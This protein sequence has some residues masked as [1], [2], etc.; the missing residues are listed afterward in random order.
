MEE[1]KILLSIGNN[2]EW[3]GKW[4]TVKKQRMKSW[5][6]AAKDCGELQT[7]REAEGKRRKSEYQFSEKKGWVRS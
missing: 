7:T 2:S 3:R 6:L 4:A 1:D 5:Q